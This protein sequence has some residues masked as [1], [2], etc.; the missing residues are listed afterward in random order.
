MGVRVPSGVQKLN[1][2]TMEFTVNKT[3]TLTIL[4]EK[5]NLVEKNGYAFMD[6]HNHCIIIVYSENKRD[7]VFEYLS[8]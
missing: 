7:L 8:K 2:N 6:K 3:S 4:D 5:R 1:D